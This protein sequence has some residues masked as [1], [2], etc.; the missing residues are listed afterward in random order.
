MGNTILTPSI[1]A[2]EALMQL[3]NNT[4][5]ASLVHRD[6]SQEFVAGVGNTVTISVNVNIKFPKNDRDF[7]PLKFWKGQGYFPHPGPLNWGIKENLTW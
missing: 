6:Y 1:I 3:R 5:M 7:S 4:V 2:K